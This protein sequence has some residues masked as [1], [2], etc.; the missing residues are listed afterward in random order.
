[1]TC[2]VKLIRY[3]GDLEIVVLTG[4]HALIVQW[5]GSAVVEIRRYNKRALFCSPESR[6]MSNLGDIPQLLSDTQT[7]RQQKDRYRSMPST[8]K[9]F[10]VYMDS[11]D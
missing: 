1:M 10:R 11:Y 6:S 5:L 4:L 9:G 3:R 8:G 7:D 2:A